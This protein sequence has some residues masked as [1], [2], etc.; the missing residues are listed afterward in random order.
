MPQPGKQRPLERSQGNRKR[1]ASL[2]HL[3]RTTLVEK[4]KR[5]GLDAD[6]GGDAI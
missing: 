1:A 3:K 4:L 5:M 6:P 2:L